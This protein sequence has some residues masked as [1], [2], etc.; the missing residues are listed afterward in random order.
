MNKATQTTDFEGDNAALAAHIHA[1]LELDAEAPEG[2]RLVH[3]DYARTLLTAAVRRLAVNLVPVP[4]CADQPM[5][6]SE[7]YNTG[8]AKGYELAIQAIEAEAR[9]PCAL[10]ADASSVLSA[11]AGVLRYDL[12]ASRKAQQPKA[13]ASAALLQ[14]ENDDLR[15]AIDQKDKENAEL[16]ERLSNLHER[17]TNLSGQLEAAQTPR[18]DAEIVAQTEAMATVLAKAD[19]W[20]PEHY[21]T[22]GYSPFRLSRHPRAQG[23][24]TRAC[25]AQELLT[26][27]DVANAIANL[28]EMPF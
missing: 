13:P 17:L 9:K 5:T 20:R 8:H 18:T 26:Q 25:L 10:L 15:A 1:V 2:L 14:A 24:W 19:G 16:R 4:T 27:T 21:D 28:D 23:Y 12:D 22:D 6:W 11:M 7:G 3:T